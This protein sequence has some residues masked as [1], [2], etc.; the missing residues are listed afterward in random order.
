MTLGK[1]KLLF[2]RINDIAMN[3]NH[4]EIEKK[5]IKNL[6][7]QMDVAGVENEEQEKYLK[8]MEEKVNISIEVNNLAEED[9]FKIGDSQIASK[10]GINYETDDGMTD[11]NTKIN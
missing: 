1:L 6:K 5:Y 2:Q 4:L 7:E 10:I 8:E 9:I 11:L 3:N